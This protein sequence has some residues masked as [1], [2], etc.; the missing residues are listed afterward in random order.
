VAGS[1]ATIAMLKPAE[2]ALAW[3]DKLGLPWLAVDA[4]ITCHGTL[5]A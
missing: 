4:D 2:E 3:L 1:S 5:A